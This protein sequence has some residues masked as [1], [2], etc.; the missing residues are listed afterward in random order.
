MKTFNLKTICTLAIM[1]CSL[2]SMANKTVRWE[3]PYVLHADINYLKLH[4][5]EFSDTA[6]IVELSTE[7]PQSPFYILSWIY[8]RGDDDKKYKIKYCKECRLNELLTAE[9]FANKENNTLTL[10]FE[11]MPKNTTTLDMLTV[12][13][14]YEF[15]FFGIAKSKKSVK[16]KPFK[17]NEQNTTCLRENFFKKDTAYIKGVIEGY[18]PDMRINSFSVYHSN[19]LTN[20]DEPFSFEIK[21]DGTFE[22]KV[23]L[24][25]PI[26]ELA[27][28]KNQLLAFYFLIR[29]GHTLN[30]VMHEDLTVDYYDESNKEVEYKEVLRF[31]PNA[32][33]GYNS[34]EFKQDVKTLNFVEYS[35]KIDSLQNKAMDLLN[36][37]A[38]RY[39]YSD[40]D[41]LIA[42]TE[43]QLSFAKKLM[44]Y[45]IYK[46]LKPN[47]G[48]PAKDNPYY[49]VIDID[50]YSALK[51]IPYNDS[52]M[53][54]CKTYSS[55]QEHYSYN[56]V[57]KHHTTERIV[58][59]NGDTINA[60]YNNTEKS[61]SICAE[62]DKKLFSTKEMSV[63]MKIHLL[64]S[65]YNKY[66]TPI[67]I[68]GYINEYKQN[69]PNADS[70]EIQRAKDTFV[71]ETKKTYQKRCEY[72]QDKNFEAKADEIFNKFL[73]DTSATYELPDCEA[74]TLLRKITDKYK[75]KIL[76]ID[77]WATFCSPCRSQIEHSKKM[78]EELR[79][80]PEV[81]F[82]FITGESDSPQ[83]T[84][85]EYVAQHLDGEDCYRV[86]D[87][88]YM[89]Y[90]ELFKFLSIPHQEVLDKNGNVLR[91]Y[92][93]ES[94][95]ETKT[96]LWNL[97]RIKEKLGQ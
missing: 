14:V 30:V 26:L 19:P 8:L 37:Y 66:K 70:I 72:F 7:N 29:P 96:F 84:Y 11:P 83:K 46:N 50:N 64:R 59:D 68:D 5:V 61:D 60:Y 41:Y 45:C 51:K 81:D 36:Y 53:L 24:S 67:N 77:F 85:D 23:V 42:K 27:L 35:R 3:K 10:V 28:P 74:T 56:R 48:M 73:Y 33:N 90:M 75:G 40:C 6:T 38:N 55:L 71:E 92:N 57:F 97:N 32:I 63:P 18:S 21:E 93:R 86:P 62:I 54:C 9:R 20:R 1:L 47:N 89:K 95:S 78:R 39:H 58:T 88:E 22:Q 4:S 43:T 12:F 87:Y 76:Y 69:N 80:N 44:D 94:F 17:Y 79:D 34:Q 16:I 25:H 13:N 49:Q 91:I 31:M 2:S 15:R 82:I 52:I 65:L